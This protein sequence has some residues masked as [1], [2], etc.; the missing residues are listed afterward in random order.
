MEPLVT[1]KVLRKYFDKQLE[2]HMQPGDVL[3]MG[4]TRAEQLANFEHNGQVLHLVEILGDFIDDD[5]AEDPLE[6]TVV[7]EEELKAKAEAK[8]AQKKA[9][10]NKSKKTT[11]KTKKR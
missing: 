7:D 5:T 2:K 11:T 1:V 6:V 9:K 4:K 3:P 10:T 8:K